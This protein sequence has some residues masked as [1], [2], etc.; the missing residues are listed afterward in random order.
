M[1][2]ETEITNMIHDHDK[3]RSCTLEV[4]LDYPVEYHDTHNEYPFAAESLN[5][6]GVKKL[7][8]NLRDKRNYVI[9]HRALKQCLENALVLR[10]IHRGIKYEETSFL[11]EYVDLNTN[12]R[13][14]S[15]NEFEKDFFKPMI[16]S[17]FSK[18]ME[19]VRCRSN[20]KIVNKKNEKKNTRSYC[21]SKPKDRI[22]L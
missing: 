8:P 19:N 11:K 20:V 4:D 1:A 12:L 21:A 7:I 6:N 2:I 13:K 16:N 22:P 5:V 17:V 10:K 18:T 15:K 3:I 9:H 14:E